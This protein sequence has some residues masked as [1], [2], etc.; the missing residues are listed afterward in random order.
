MPEMIAWVGS[1]SLASRSGGGAVEG[2]VGEGERSGFVDGT[3]GVVEDGGGVVVA[4]EADSTSGVSD[5]VAWVVGVEVAVLGCAVADGPSSMTRRAIVC[6]CVSV[7]AKAAHT[8]TAPI[9][10]ASRRRLVPTG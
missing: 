3:G 6:S 8:A 9:H 5:V 4:A 7:A 1:I 2:R 10:H